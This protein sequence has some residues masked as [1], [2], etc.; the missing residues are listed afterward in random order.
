MAS[1][2]S[3]KNRKFDP[4]AFDGGERARQETKFIIYNVYL[5]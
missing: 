4:P 3:T 2:E 1:G 5:G